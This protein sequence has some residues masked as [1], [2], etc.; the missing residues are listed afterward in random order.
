MIDEMLQ[1]YQASTPILPN[2]Q[3][4]QLLSRRTG[5]LFNVEFHPVP[6]ISS[7]FHIDFGC[8]IND[9]TIQLFE[10]EPPL[11]FR[12]GG[13][14][15]HHSNGGGGGSQQ[16]ADNG[17][18]ND[19]YV[20]AETDD[21]KVILSMWKYETDDGSEAFAASV[22][23]FEQGRLYTIGKG[24]L[25]GSFTYIVNEYFPE[26]LPP[27]D[28][29]STEEGRRF[30]LKREQQQQAQSS[31]LLRGGSSNPAIA[32]E[33]TTGTMMTN[34]RQVDFSSEYDGMKKYND[35]RNVISRDLQVET[36]TIDL[37]LVWSKEAECLES[38]LSPSCTPNAGTETTMRARLDLAVSDLN[39]AYQN[40]NI[41]AAF[42]VVHAYRHPTYSDAG[43]RSVDI[44][45]NIFEVDDG[46][47]DDI[48]IER[49]NHCADMVAFIG[50]GRNSWCGVA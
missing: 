41:D 48:P 33:T 31:S 5:E 1:E 24:F 14:G 11:N 23:D 3:T 44:L 28:E 17:Q 45:F 29:L 21:Q 25:E 2:Q 35:P 8:T 9:V 19:Q 20:Y 42:N 10:D 34:G 50:D 26:D 49:A 4:S 46:E 32:T 12:G 7:D 13:A 39:M 27:E 18:N 40:S 47:L 38:N 36:D 22:N 16:N 43:K 37:M 6:P 30:L 15:C